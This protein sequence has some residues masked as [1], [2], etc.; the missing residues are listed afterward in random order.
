[1][2]LLTTALISKLIL[3]D[4]SA[5]AHKKASY[6]L[7]LGN[8]YLK[9]VALTLYKSRILSLVDYGDVCYIGANKSDLKKIQLVQNKKITIINLANRYKSNLDSHCRYNLLPLCLR[10]QHNL[11]KAVPIFMLHNSE[12]ITSARGSTVNSVSRVK[13]SL[14]HLL[15][16]RYVPIALNSVI[17]GPVS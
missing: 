2:L 8:I 7:K 6:S 11:L 13:D 14:M 4:W 15:S 10:R 12:E 17:Q 1:M 3:V 16:S 5:F 9:G